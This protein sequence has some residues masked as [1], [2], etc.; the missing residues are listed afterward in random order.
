MAEPAPSKP[1]LIRRI[2]RWMRW[3]VLAGFLGLILLVSF[4]RQIILWAV[5]RFGPDAAKSAGLTLKMK[6]NGS[7]W[8]DLDISDLEASSSDPA[9]PLRDLKLGK[10]ALRYDVAPVWAG[11]Y[12][13]IPKASLC[14]T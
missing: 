5:N 14:T 12:F 7:L 11:D 2:W 1:S 6:A 4:H 3:F 10:L 9:M 8:S 13:K